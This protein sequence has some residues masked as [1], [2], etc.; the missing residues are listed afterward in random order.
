MKI[1][2][3][4]SDKEENSFMSL[5][6]SEIYIDGKKWDLKDLENFSVYSSIVCNIVAKCKTT[7]KLVELCKVDSVSDAEDIIREITNYMSDVY[8]ETPYKKIIST[9]LKHIKNYC[10]AINGNC[11]KCEIIKYSKYTCAGC[12]RQDFKPMNW[13]LR[14]DVSKGRA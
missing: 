10:V 1:L 11:K 6:G 5:E 14:V 2:L 4:T 9:S 8:G 3:H 7:G 13:E 12:Y